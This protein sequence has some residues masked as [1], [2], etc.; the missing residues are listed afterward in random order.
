MRP[1]VLAHRW[2]GIAFCL[3]FAMWFASGIVMRFI[4]Y[5]SLTEEERIAGLATPADVREIEWFSFGGRTYKRERL[6]FKAQ[7]LSLAADPASAVGDRL[8]SQD[9]QAVA[10]RLS[11]HCGRVVA[12]EASDPYPVVRSMPDAPVYRFACGDTWFQVD[13]ANGAILEKLDAS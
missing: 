9:V 4:A 2:L 6:T 13:S 3:L 12:V 8:V 5:P 10:S 7:R 1:L 11:P